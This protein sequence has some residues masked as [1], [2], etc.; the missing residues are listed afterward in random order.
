MLIAH[1]VLVGL[2][3]VVLITCSAWR[4]WHWRREIAGRNR[5]PG[6]GDDSVVFARDFDATTPAG[7]LGSGWL[8]ERSWHDGEPPKGCYSQAGPACKCG[9]LVVVLLVLMWHLVAFG[10]RTNNRL[11][12]SL[13]LSLFLSACLCVCCFRAAFSSHLAVYRLQAGCGCE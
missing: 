3:I 4:T 1:Y 9:T 11:F 6:R 2:A 5:R 8:S 12:L 10:G 7:V 13:Y